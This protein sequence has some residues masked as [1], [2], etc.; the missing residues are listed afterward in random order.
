MKGRRV[1]IMFVVEV[2]F[3]YKKFDEAQVQE[4]IECLL[5]S[6]RMNGQVLGREYPVAIVEES[7]HT[8]L[9]VPEENSLDK[10]RANVYALKWLSKL[11]DLDVE[12]S[13]K[14]VGSEPYSASVCKCTRPNFY[15]L[16]T[17]YLSLESPMSCGDCF[18]SVPL[19]RIPATKD[20]EYVDIITWESDYKAC[21]TLQMNCSTGERFGVRQ[22][23][24][25]ESSLSKRGMDI[26]N[27]ITASTG[28]PT[29]Y[30]L[31]KPTGIGS[32]AEKARKCPSCCGEWLLNEPLHGVF[33]FRC[34]K[35][36]LLSNIAWS[37]RSK[38]R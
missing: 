29:Y 21:D 9:L 13:W 14:V 11:D 16:Y 17:T 8:Y 15:I 4:V 5:G 28:I 2:I 33:D 3:K 35:C 34:D 38:G 36:M 10:S 37:V 25:Y 27:Q 7:F 18:G 19:Y 32:K 20:E 31:L 26:C 1:S 30:Y 12:Y 22:L 24:S 23:S 6:L